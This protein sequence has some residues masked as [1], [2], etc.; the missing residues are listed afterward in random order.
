M[1]EN[2]LNDVTDDLKTSLKGIR[3]GIHMSG[4]FFS[5]KEK[6]FS[7]ETVLPVRFKTPQ[8]TNRM[9]FDI[10]TSCMTHDPRNNENRD[11]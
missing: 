5:L 2:W 1:I 11:L 7:S 10:Y 4:V 9:A 8:N 3:F 6:A